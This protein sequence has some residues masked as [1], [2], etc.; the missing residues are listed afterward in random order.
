MHLFPAKAIK[1]SL[2]IVILIG[3]GLSSCSVLS[4]CTLYNA[5]REKKRYRFHVFESPPEISFK[6]NNRYVVHCG[7]IFENSRCYG[8][9]EHNDSLFSIKSV[10]SNCG[11]NFSTS[12][13]YQDS[14]FYELKDDSIVLNLWYVK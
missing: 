5:V 6:K 14:V 7:K 10:N 2:N 3:L 1:F 12:F 9:Y 4:G 13:F 11:C 8:K